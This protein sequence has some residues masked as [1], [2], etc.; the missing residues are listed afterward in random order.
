MPTYSLILPAHN[1]EGVIVALVARLS[2]VMD[3]L[4]GLS[5]MEGPRI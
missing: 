5:L 2:A 1:E 4:D 3:A